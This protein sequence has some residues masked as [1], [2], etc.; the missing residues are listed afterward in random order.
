M[1]SDFQCQKTSGCRRHNFDS[2]TVETLDC[3]LYANN[4]K[5]EYRVI[6]I[7]L[8]VFHN[9]NIAYSVFKYLK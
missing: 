4:Y 2:R 3:F 8:E 5:I 7:K 6:C 9:P 1:V